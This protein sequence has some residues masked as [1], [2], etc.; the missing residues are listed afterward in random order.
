MA[1]VVRVL[2][3]WSGSSEEEA[4]WEDFEHLKQTF[5]RAPAWGQAGSQEE[6]NA[7]PPAPKLSRQQR[8]NQEEERLKY[9]PVDEAVM[10]RRSKRERRQNERFKGPDWTT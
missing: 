2:V 3:Q 5:P 10:I 9:G 4:T 7:T 6:G 8:R 1:T